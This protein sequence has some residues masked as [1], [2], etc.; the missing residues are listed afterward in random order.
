MVEGI[1]TRFLDNL[2]EGS[3][4]NEEFFHGTLDEMERMSVCFYLNKRGLDLRK[5]RNK[6]LIKVVRKK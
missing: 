2:K 1:R 5:V 6:T 3:F 4:I